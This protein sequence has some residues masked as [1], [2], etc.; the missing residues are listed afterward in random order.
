MKTGETKDDVRWCETC[1]QFHG[2]LYVCGSYPDELKAKLHEQSEKYVNNL[3]SRSWCER[4]KRER[5]ID[6]MGIEIF[7][8]M[9][10]IEE[11]DWT[12]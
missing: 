8:A 3:R 7:R 6:D 9:A 10:G 11:G 12:A 2:I 4:Q 5:G 1:N